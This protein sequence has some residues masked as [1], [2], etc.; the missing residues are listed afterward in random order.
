MFN[1]FQ[2][3]P[4]RGTSMTAFPYQGL[5][6][7][8]PHPVNHLHRIRRISRAMVLACV[9]L[10][11]ALPLA[12]VYFWATTGAAGLAAQGQLPPGAI[13]A[14]LQLWQRVTA[15]A[16]TFVPLALLLTGIWQA[17][18]CFDQFARGEVFTAPATAQ[19]RRLAGW[20][21][22]AAFA[23]VVAGALTSV[24]LT[25][26]NPPGARHLAIGISSNHIFTLF[27]AGLVWLMADIIGQGQ[28][29]ADENQS[30]V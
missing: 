24:L 8:V 28:A 5:D 29:L 19:L 27:F 3:R 30:F 4:P 26:N 14:P 9:A 15:A 18:R 25:L 23:A 10:V 17:K 2:A 1:L 12:F 20:V 22:A 7:P 16:V 13:Q 21:A 11:V 6:Q